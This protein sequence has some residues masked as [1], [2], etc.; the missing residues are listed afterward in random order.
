MVKQSGNSHFWARLMDV[1]LLLEKG[2]TKV[3]SGNL[4]RF[5]KDIW[6]VKEPLKLKYPSLYITVRRK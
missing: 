5:W 1:N 2:R 3:N 4:T 6:I